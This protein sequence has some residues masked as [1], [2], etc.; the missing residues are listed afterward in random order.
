MHTSEEEQ[1]AGKAV[2]EVLGDLTHETIV[3]DEPIQVLGHVPDAR[4]LGE[5]FLRELEYQ[6]YKITRDR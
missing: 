4:Q 5:R 1:A 2:S 3:E 6:G